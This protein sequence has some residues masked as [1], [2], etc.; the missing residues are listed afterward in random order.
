MAVNPSIGKNKLLN[1]TKNENW[2]N[3]CDGK[4]IHATQDI[5]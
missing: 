5:T 1:E 3:R 4:R 2:R